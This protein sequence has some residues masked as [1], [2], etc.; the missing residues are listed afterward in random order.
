MSARRAAERSSSR[1]PVSVLGRL[2]PPLGN[3]P[4]SLATRPLSR[5]LV[6]R[7][8]T[9]VAAAGLGANNGVKRLPQRL[10]A[11]SRTNCRLAGQNLV[12]HV[13]HY[14]FSVHGFPFRR[15]R[16]GGRGLELLCSGLLPSLFIIPQARRN[17]VVAPRRALRISSLV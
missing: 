15:R 6:A 7:H 12:D 14:L 2:A 13:G 1:K 10:P 17:F 5:S 16:S 4:D 9:P 3:K 11:P 8:A